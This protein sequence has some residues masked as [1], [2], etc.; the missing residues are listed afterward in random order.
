MKTQVSRPNIWKTLE[1]LKLPWEPM[2]QKTRKTIV[3]SEAYGKHLEN[4]RFR[5]NL[6][7]TLR[8]LMFSIYTD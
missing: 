6:W 5:W 4:T 8:K 2:E 7:K 1:N 3:L